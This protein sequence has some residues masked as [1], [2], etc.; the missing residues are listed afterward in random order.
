MRTY[1][2]YERDGEGR[3][4]RVPFFVSC[5]DDDEA[6]HLARQ[7]ARQVVKTHALEIWRKVITIEPSRLTR[8]HDGRKAGWRRREQASARF[9]TSY[10]ASNRL[11]RSRSPS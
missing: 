10:R 11:M 1:R 7:V 9:R 4:G 5:R 8:T 3:S 6:A 2:I